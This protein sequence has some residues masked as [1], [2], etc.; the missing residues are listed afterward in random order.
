MATTSHNESV[1]LLQAWLDRQLDGEA[2]DWL[3]TR[4]A[5]L[6]AGAGDRALFMA[7]SF[8]Q[9][10]LGKADL[11]LDAADLEA[12][13]A[14]RPGWDPADWS[15]DQAAR[16]LLLL[17]GGGSGAEFAEKLKKLM[18]TSDVA[19]TIA[20][21]RGLPLYPDPEFHLARAREG[22][23]SNMRPVFEAVAH[24]NPYPVEVFDDNAWNHM[25]L[26]ALF[27][28]STLHPIQG[29][30]AR[31]NPELASMLRD[32]AHERWAAGRPV[33]PELWRCIGRFADGEALADL[34]RVLTTGTGSEREG[35]ALALADCPKAEAE[36][37]LGRAPDLAAAIAAGTLTWTTLGQKL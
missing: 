15:V 26:K 7:I 37:L 19:E 11:A 23:R 27:V 30:E 14:A 22:A 36:D 13:Q 33:T 25:V 34:E 10:R 32:Y 4:L 3:H 29:L 2:R 16:I 24:R 5:E 1:R 35:A 8:V 21:L 12:A 9:R 28:G 17:Q 20:F 31:A 18:A 6:A